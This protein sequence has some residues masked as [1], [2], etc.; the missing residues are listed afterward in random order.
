MMQMNI[1][2][3]IGDEHGTHK[4]T[5]GS[6]ILYLYHKVARQNNALSVLYYVIYVAF[7][8]YMLHGFEIFSAPGTIAHGSIRLPPRSLASSYYAFN[9]SLFLLR[10]LNKFCFFVAVALPSFILK[11]YLLFHVLN[12]KVVSI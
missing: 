10:C 4:H 9:P 2:P 1:H 8:N 12:S 7:H 11:C 3:T 6:W 5:H